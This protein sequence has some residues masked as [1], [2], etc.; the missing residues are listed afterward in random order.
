MDS[1]TRHP[2]GPLHLRNLH[3]GWG[4]FSRPQGR[5]FCLL[6]DCSPY[7]RSLHPQKQI[8]RRR[9]RVHKG[10]VQMAARAVS[11]QGHP[12]T[13]QGITG[14]PT[15]DRQGGQ[16]TE[17]E[18]TLIL[19]K[20]TYKAFSTRITI[21]SI[22]ACSLGYVCYSFFLLLVGQSHFFLL[23]GPPHFLFLLI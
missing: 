17:P 18:K 13:V 8:L 3:F 1:D 11:N 16:D 22:C 14:K 12:W 23:I 6:L 7:Q 4:C 10:S 2:K 21:P 20:F 5:Y 15:A 19:F 9:L